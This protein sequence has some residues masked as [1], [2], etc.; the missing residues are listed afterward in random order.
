MSDFFYHYPSTYY[1]FD[2]ENIN[3]GTNI[4]SRFIFQ[5]QFKNNPFAFYD[6]KIK[7]GDTLKY[8]HTNY[9]VV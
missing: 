9:M 4:I 7:D 8:W 5:E 3:L 2:D 6:Y 1:S